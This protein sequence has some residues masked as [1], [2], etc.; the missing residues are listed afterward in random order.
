MYLG[1]RTYRKPD[2][3]NGNKHKALSVSKSDARYQL[4]VYIKACQARIYIVIFW[5]QVN[6][7][8]IHVPRKANHTQAKGYHPI[9]LLY[10]MQKMMQKLVARN[11]RFE[12]LGYIPY[13]YNNLPTNQGSPQKLQCI[14]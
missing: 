7:T 2:C 4:Y 3:N 13:I 8:F 12:T 6:L 14:M 10:F 11:I 1:S 5:G 9:S